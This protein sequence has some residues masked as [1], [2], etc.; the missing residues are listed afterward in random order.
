MCVREEK[1]EHAQKGNYQIV[2]RF[3]GGLGVLRCEAGGR[4]LS[5]T[6]CGDT[7][8]IGCLSEPGRPSSG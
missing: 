3:G 1:R 5:S 7:R 6:V 4:S 2:P 8:R